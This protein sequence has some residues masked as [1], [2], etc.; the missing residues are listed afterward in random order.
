MTHPTDGNCIF[1][2]IVAGQIPCFKLL[3]D[4][5]TIAMGLVVLAVLATS[6]LLTAFATNLLDLSVVNPDAL[7]SELALAMGGPVLKIL[8]VATA[9]ALTH[10]DALVP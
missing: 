2:K 8:L 1:C 10:P 6:P 7:Q 5:N 3:E 4:D 9:S